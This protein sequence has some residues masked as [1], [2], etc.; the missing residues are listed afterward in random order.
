VELR[1]NYLSVNKTKTKRGNRILTESLHKP[2]IFSC[3]PLNTRRAE[4]NWAEAG[5]VIADGLL[6]IGC[7]P[8]IVLLNRARD[9][10][11]VI[12]FGQKDRINLIIKRDSYAFL[13][14]TA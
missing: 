2:H 9:T 11:T 6:V 8:S 14:I 4:R 1:K 3:L 7:G 10:S 5:C 13:R 12:I